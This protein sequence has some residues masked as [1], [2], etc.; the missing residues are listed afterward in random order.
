VYLITQ[1]IIDKTKILIDAEIGKDA[2]TLSYAYSNVESFLTPITGYFKTSLNVDTKLYLF[3]AAYLKNYWAPEYWHRQFGLTYDD[4]Y[5]FH[6]SRNLGETFNI[7]V[8]YVHSEKTDKTTLNNIMGKNTKTN[9]VGSFDEIRIFVKLFFDVTSRFT[10]SEDYAV[11][12]VYVTLSD[13]EIS[14][15]QDN[16]IVIIPTALSEIGIN[17]WNVYIKGT[18]GNIVKTYSGTNEP[19]KDLPWNG[20]EENGRTLTE[21]TYDVT[22]EA[23]DKKGGYSVSEPLKVEV[24]K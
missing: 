4:L 3:K 1:F 24:S 20:R 9:E 16:D 17:R 12:K 19:P 7:G 21:G 23:W 2:A 10:K 14:S 22:I 15:K 13:A 8:E 5:L 18:A 6:A 11:P